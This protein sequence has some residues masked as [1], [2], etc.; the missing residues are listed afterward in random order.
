MYLHNGGAVNCGGPICLSMLAARQAADKEGLNRLFNSGIIFPPP[1]GSQEGEKNEKKEEQE[2]K[3]SGGEENSDAQENKEKESP[4]PGNKNPEEADKPL[5]EGAAKTE[6]DGKKSKQSG[7][8]KNSHEE[9]VKRPNTTPIYAACWSTGAYR[10]GFFE[11]INKRWWSSSS[12]VL[13]NPLWPTYFTSCRAIPES[14][15]HLTS[16]EGI[17]NTLISAKADEML[18]QDPDYIKLEKAEKKLRDTPGSK[19]LTNVLG[20][21]GVGGNL[22]LDNASS[23]INSLNKQFI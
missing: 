11:E 3:G 10:P 21:F 8:D 22:A 9:E 5:E 7:A 14:V 19:F 6:D 15:A 1:S 18:R 17:R 2:K 16:D 4:D 13:S 23:G 20:E 12:D